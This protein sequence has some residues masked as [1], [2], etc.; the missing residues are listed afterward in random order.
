MILNCGCNY[1]WLSV[2]CVTYNA[3]KAVIDNN[4]LL[5]FV[6]GTNVVDFMHPDDMVAQGNENLSDLA[7]TEPLY[8]QGNIDM[9]CDS[10]D[11]LCQDDHQ[12]EAISDTIPLE[13][14]SIVVTN[15]DLSNFRA[16]VIHD[17]Q[18]LGIDSTETQQTVNFLSES[19]ANMARNDEIV[20]LDE[21]T[22][23]P[24]QLLVPRKKKLKKKQ[25]EAGRGFKVDASSRSPH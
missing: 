22:S 12:E 3:T 4:A 18:V 5:G 9:N 11:I 23:Q 13:G 25:H 14:N 20:D 6:N 15:S 1:I 2:E 21:N 7:G 16:S 17:M 24:F 8:G 10:A 19:W